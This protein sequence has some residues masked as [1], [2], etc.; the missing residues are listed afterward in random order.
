MPKENQAAGNRCTIQMQL[1]Q[2]L[3]DETVSTDET[4]LKTDKTANPA[5]FSRDRLITTDTNIGTISC[6]Q[7]DQT[8][9]LYELLLGAG[10]WACILSM[11]FSSS[12]VG[13]LSSKPTAGMQDRRRQMPI[14]LCWLTGASFSEPSSAG[15]PA[16]SRLL[17]PKKGSW[18]SPWGR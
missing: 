3:Q 5:A 6:H 11:C 7:G 14:L 18:F 1:Y 12:S 16:A 8:L 17:R 9:T 10:I 13:S 15:C 2:L 4:W